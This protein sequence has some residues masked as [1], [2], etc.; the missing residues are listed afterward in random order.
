M[1]DQPLRPETLI[2]VAQSARILAKSAYSGGWSPWVIDFYGDRDTCRYSEKYKQVTNS[3]ENTL[4]NA[5]I[6]A[7]A[8][9]TDNKEAALIVGSGFDGR[10]NLIG[11]LRQHYAHYGNAAQTIKKVKQPDSFFPLLDRL[12][13][14]YPA[15]RFSKPMRK[16]GWLLKYSGGEGGR[17]VWPAGEINPPQGATKFYYQ[18]RLQGQGGSV[19]FLA[20]GEKHCI[21][22]FNSQWTTAV[23]SRYPFQFGGIANWI[24]LSD[25][26]RQRLDCYIADIVRAIS[27][28][29]LNSLDFIVDGERCVILEINPRPSASMDLYDEHFHHGLVDAHIRACQGDLQSQCHCVNLKATSIVFARESL[30]VPYGQDWPEWSADRPKGGTVIAA[31]QPLCSVSASGDDPHDVMRKLKRRRTE[32]VKQLNPQLA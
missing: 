24:D 18:R 5:I 16:E 30:T 1:L 23:D 10:P 19:L 8:S 25:D 13:I 12:Q 9:M 11:F 7:I 20:D 3:K 6:G 32:I 31:F 28:K 4:D 21:I 22:G 14:P 29:G 17:G 15:I 27:L 2:L 26:Q